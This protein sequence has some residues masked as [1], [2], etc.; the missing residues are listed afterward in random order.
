MIIEVYDNY[1]K[2]YLNLLKFIFLQ[3]DAIASI[4]KNFLL[5]FSFSTK[6][7]KDELFNNFGRRG[8]QFSMLYTTFISDFY[9]G[10]IFE[11][12][13]KFGYFKDLSGKFSK[14]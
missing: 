10:I 8:L 14:I 13:L 3:M 2:I 1:N 6:K 12:S 11:Q 4:C 7:A 5:K 9:R